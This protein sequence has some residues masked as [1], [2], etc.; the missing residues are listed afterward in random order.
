LEDSPLG[1]FACRTLERIAAAG[2]EAALTCL[3]QA[4]TDPA[5]PSAIRIEAGEAYA[6]IRGLVPKPESAKRPRSSAKQREPITTPTAPFVVS[7]QE[8]AVAYLAGCIAARGAY[9]SSDAARRMAG[10]I[11]QHGR[12]IHSGMAVRMLQD[13]AGLDMCPEHARAM[14]SMV[15]GSDGDLIQPW[16][17]SGYGYF[18]FSVQTQVHVSS[19]EAENEFRGITDGL[20]GISDELRLVP[21]NPLVVRGRLTDALARRLALILG[22]V[23]EQ[24]ATNDLRA[25][26]VPDPLA[27]MSGIADVAGNCRFANRFIDGRVRVRIDILNTRNSWRFPVELCHVLQHRL[28]IPVQSVTWGHPNL[29]R[30]LREHQMNVFAGDFQAVGFRVPHKQQELIKYRDSV[31]AD[32]GCPGLRRRVAKPRS[33][34]EQSLEL[35]DSLRGH[36]FDAYWE[37][38]RAMSCR[39]AERNGVAVK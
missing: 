36:H 4:A 12:R 5:V 26:Q 10:V 22:N 16:V 7:G 19:V 14:L 18:A 9:V 15:S 27:F 20:A 6:R 23:A 11:V 31:S 35:P 30:G 25:D 1:F 39:D 38:C 21:G 28:R 3:R 2:S 17:E 33:S 37:I 29:G 34:E 24:C 13:Q 8:S 32:E